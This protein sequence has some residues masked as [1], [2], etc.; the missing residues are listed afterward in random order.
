MIFHSIGILNFYITNFIFHVLSNVLATRKWYCCPSDIYSTR[1]FY[2]FL[3]FSCDTV[4]R[5]MWI[6]A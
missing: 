1:L 2:S 6:N 5:W 3:C 4:F